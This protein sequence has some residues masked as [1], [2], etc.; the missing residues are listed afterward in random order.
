M[1]NLL[2]TPAGVRDLYDNELEKK[3]AVSEKLCDV[4]KK[5]DFKRIQTPTYEF[6][7]IYAGQYT[8]DE[9]N[10]FRFFDRE[11]NTLVMRP[12]ITPSV[13]RSVAKYY[14]ADELPVKLFYEGNIFV[15][16]KNHSGRAA[17]TTQ[18]GAEYM[19]DGSVSADAQIL[20]M[21][22][23]C[24]KAAGL[25]DFKISIGY[26]GIFDSICDSCD[27]SGSDK[28]DILNFV[29]NKNFIGMRNK[30]NELTCD[31]GKRAL[32]SILSRVY[33]DAGEF[34]LD[35]D[36]IK[37]NDE[38]IH[39]LSRLRELSA[40]LEKENIAQ[41]FVYDFSILS[42]YPYYTGIIFRGYSKGSG[43]SI[44]K[45][46]RYDQLLSVFGRDAAAVGLAIEVEQLLNALDKA[47]E[48]VNSE[49]YLTFALG[50]GRLANKTMA[51]LEKLGIFCEQMRDPD[52]RKLIFVNEEYKMRFFLA[53][54]P[55]VP[56]YVEYGAADIGIVGKDTI[57]EEARKVYEVL[58]LGFGKC[59]MCVCGPESAAELLKHH[60][61]IRVA[62]KYPNIA[63]DYFYNEKDQ[64]V[65]F[66]KLNGS[67]ELAPIVGLSDV[68]V[69][70]VETGS[71][72]REN[73]LKVLEEVRPLSARMI[74][75]RASM[76]TQR[77]RISQLAEDLNRIL[78]EEA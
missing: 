5:F 52:T 2:H 48:P 14:T 70:I 45:G 49:G 51:A 62:T 73:G 9:N 38:I 27:I 57:D 20:Q 39:A 71:T 4:I 35:Y 58:D 78:N 68:I 32:F 22:V 15:N 25:N 74:V 65:E 24:L 41:Y 47:L 50:K 42:N 16:Q 18:I 10:M 8:K 33:K 23:E 44:V 31:E 37:S 46:G 64:T 7:D 36:T 66:I 12:D 77:E 13:A 21:A 28:D 59:K 67:I 54:G 75:N 69:D 61:M 30:V 40:I 26:A 72:L 55:D 3:L 19:G 1:S 43:A 53:K 17:E 56:T 76:D 60:E 34:P 29:S 11:G 6:S 63:K